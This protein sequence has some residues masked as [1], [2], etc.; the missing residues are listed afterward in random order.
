M[1]G[2]KGQLKMSKTVKHIVSF[3]LILVMSSFIVMNVSAV[4]SMTGTGAVTIPTVGRL[5]TNDIDTTATT[6]INSALVLLGLVA[7]VIVLMGG[8]KWMTSAGNEEKVGEA[9]KLLGAGVI[10]LI[11]VF[12]AWG[13]ANFIMNAAQSAA[14]TT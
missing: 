3:M 10:G 4:T 11:I 8:F 6:I 5:G 14:T 9:K 2:K 7:L 1:M 13:I 12:A